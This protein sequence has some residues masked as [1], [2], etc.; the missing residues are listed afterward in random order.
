MV[1]PHFR[2]LNFLLQGWLMKIV[3]FCI[4]IILSG[5]VVAP[6]IDYIETQA[7]VKK[8]EFLSSYKSERANM[9]YAGGVFLAI[10]TKENI[11]TYI[12]TLE[13]NDGVQVRVASELSLEIL[14]CVIMKHEPLLINDDPEYNFVVGELV[15]KKRCD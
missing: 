10:P 3:L 14:D 12:Y 2:D 9:V 4:V 15:K 5:C 8:S 13:I 7:I 1:F 11:E 6:S